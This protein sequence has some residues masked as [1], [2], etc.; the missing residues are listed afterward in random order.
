MPF[1]LP[2]VPYDGLAG[3]VELMAFDLRLGNH[4][5]KVRLFTNDYT[6]VN[7]TVVSDLVEY[8]GWGYTPKNLG[9]PV[10]QG[11][12][13]TGRDVWLFPEVE[14]I[15]SGSGS[16][17]IVWGYW[18]DFTAPLTGKRRLLTIQRFNAS[19]VFLNAGDRIRFTPS[20]GMKQ[21]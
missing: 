1:Y 10:D 20:W 3:V 7:S 8:S 12:D 16:T 5:C 21:C 13:V 11:V 14:W 6:P 2:I 9:N 17:N 4:G 18:I 15:A 19:Q